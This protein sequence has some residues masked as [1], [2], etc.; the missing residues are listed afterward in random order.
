MCLASRLRRFAALSYAFLSFAGCGP[1]EGDAVPFVGDLPRREVQG[2]VF[3]Q[4]TPSLPDSGHPSWFLGAEFYSRP[5]VLLDRT[6]MVGQ[7]GCGREG[8]ILAETVYVESPEPVVVS[9]GGQEYTLPRDRPDRPDLPPSYSLLGEFPV[10]DE[11]SVVAV[12]G[13]DLEVPLPPA[14]DQF[15]EPDLL[16]AVRSGRP[17]L[18]APA[19]ADVVVVL[20]FG[21]EDSSYLCF[22]Q[23]D[24]EAQ[25][26]EEVV[27]GGRLFDLLM[28]YAAS[29]DGQFGGVATNLYVQRTYVLY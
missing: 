18:W 1:D 9:L 23:D 2:S 27:F 8:P 14:P 6:A 3:V 4:H 13:T 15:S 22:L 16:D 5:G 26:P 25:L 20:A 11:P 17:L 12:D 28:G 24:G 7:E 19:D 29:V 21:D 10:P